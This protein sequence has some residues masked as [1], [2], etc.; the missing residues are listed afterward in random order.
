MIWSAAANPIE[1]RQ[2][3]PTASPAPRPP[4]ERDL[5]T[6]TDAAGTA[7]SAS[8]VI[9]VVGLGYVGL[10]LAMAFARR[11]FP[12]RGFDID[13]ARVDA[14]VQG[15]DWTGEVTEAEL[16]DQAPRFTS[17]PDDLA[18]VSFFVVTVPTPVDATN[19]PDMRFLLDAC[20]TIGP[21]L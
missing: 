3:K 8:E 7:G 21:R 16:R 6:A 17:D 13:A 15:V 9:G 20:R 4:W 1:R 2:G 18:D 12:V 5:A 10:P 11:G 14:L 19:Q